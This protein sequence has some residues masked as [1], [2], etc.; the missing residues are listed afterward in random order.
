MV[1]LKIGSYENYICPKK[2]KWMTKQ[3]LKMSD[4]FQVVLLSLKNE[5]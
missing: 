2:D 5:G 3:T 4:N 1:A